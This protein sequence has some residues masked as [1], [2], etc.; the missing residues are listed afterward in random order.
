MGRF[1][2]GVDVVIRCVGM[3]RAYG[4]CLPLLSGTGGIS[5]FGAHVGPRFELFDPVLENPRFCSILR[6]RVGHLHRISTAPVA[7]SDTDDPH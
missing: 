4:P 2:W 1:S 5:A 7:T 6:M 3:T